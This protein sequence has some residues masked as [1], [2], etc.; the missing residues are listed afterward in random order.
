MR[1]QI[2]GSIPTGGICNAYHVEKTSSKY[3]TV[4]SLFIFSLQ[5]LGFLLVHSYLSLRYI[6]GEV[7]SSEVDEE[8]RCYVNVRR[9]HLWVDSCRHFKKSTFDPKTVVSVKFADTSGNSE[10]SVDISWQSEGNTL[11]FF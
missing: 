8:E 7:H 2:S 4:L 1:M 5:S 10:G 9:G 6:L 3:K 11:S